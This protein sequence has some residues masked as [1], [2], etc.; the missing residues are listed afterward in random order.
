MVSKPHHLSLSAHGAIEFA[1]GIATM[2]APV[3]FGFA[4]AGI[5][6]SFALGALLIGMSLP[7]TTRGS[8]TLSWHRDFDSV[9]LIGTAIAALALALDGEGA[10]GIFLAAL[11][12]VQSAL[13]LGTRYTATG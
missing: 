13:L 12:A 6:I 7:L 8:S 1:A 3:V 2:V 11:V 5:I 4:P 10:A 9:F